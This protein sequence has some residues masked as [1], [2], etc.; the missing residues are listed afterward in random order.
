MGL[1]DPSVNPALAVYKML[2]SVLNKTD[3]CLALMEL[4]TW[5]EGQARNTQ[6]LF[7]NW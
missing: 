5:Q 3:V 2:S 7:C 6:P 4:V 1:G